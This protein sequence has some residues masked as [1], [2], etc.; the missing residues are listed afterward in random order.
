VGAVFTRASSSAVSVRFSSEL[1]IGHSVPHPSILERS[2]SKGGFRDDFAVLEVL[3]KGFRRF[4]TSYNLL[5]GQLR[6]GFRKSAAIE[7]NGSP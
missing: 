7:A 5:Y 4:L 3:G 1:F 2:F 6:L